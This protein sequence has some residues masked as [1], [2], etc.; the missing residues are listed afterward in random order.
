[1]PALDEKIFD[2]ARLPLAQASHLPGTIYVSPQVYA[3]EK[4]KIFMKDWLCVARAEEVERPGD[5]MTLRVLDE[6][7]VLARAADGRLH[8]FANVCAHRGVE[9]ASGRGNARH[10][11]CPYHGWA[12]DLAGKLTGAAFMKDTANFD[13][14]A[15]RLP[16]IA[17]GEW[18]GWVF[19]NFDPAAEPLAAFVAD[20]EE[21]FGLLN[22]ETCRLAF[23]TEVEIECNWKLVV[24]NLTDIY[25]SEVLH[26]KTFGG[27]IKTEEIKSA[28]KRCGGNSAFYGAAPHNPEAR[29]Y[30]GKM[31]WLADRPESFARSGFLAPNFDMFCR[32]DEVHPVVSWPLSPTRTKIVLYQLFPETAF[33]HADFAQK[34]PLYRDYMLRI[35]EEDR[36]MIESLQSAMSTRHYRPGRM[37]HLE[38]GIHNIIG[39]YL[40][41]MFGGAAG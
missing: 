7:V 27:H 29:A 23:K 34:A 9:V 17:I 32:I 33:A 25:H 16:P 38:R 11:S 21:D 12:Y 20:Y 30:F 14:A 18:R 31:P 6:P 3:R 40:E 39:Y 26:K 22:M 5:Y 41:R 24:E 19:V 10:F 2:A 4:E 35:V 13:F 28:L 36:G 37:S 15:C 1:M 8:S